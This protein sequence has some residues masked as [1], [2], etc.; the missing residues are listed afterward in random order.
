MTQALTQMMPTRLFLDDESVVAIMCHA[1][2]IFPALHGQLAWLSLHDSCSMQS[3]W[4]APQQ[5][6]DA[7][8]VWRRAAVFA[9]AALL[10]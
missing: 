4:H 7:H 9:G 10:H 3:A 5:Q 1:S 8:K 6:C 2:L